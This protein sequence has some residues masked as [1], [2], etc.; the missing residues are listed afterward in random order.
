LGQTPTHK[1]GV[2]LFPHTHKTKTKRTTKIRNPKKVLKKPP[3][4]GRQ[5]IG[6]KQYK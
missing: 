5:K 4:K 2:Y 1:G 6:K 3:K